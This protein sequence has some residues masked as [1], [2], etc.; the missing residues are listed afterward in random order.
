[1]DLV[2]GVLARRIPSEEFA[3]SLNAEQVR[4]ADGF[5]E[6]GAEVYLVGGKDSFTTA[7]EVSGRCRRRASVSARRV[8]Q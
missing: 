3:F 8:L 5:T 7:T 6:D 1:V 2:E 4:P